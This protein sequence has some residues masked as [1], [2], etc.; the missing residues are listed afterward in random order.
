MIFFLFDCG[1]SVKR[2]EGFFCNFFLNSRNVVVLVKLV[3]SLWY[4][5][6]I[7]MHLNGN[8]WNSLQITYW[9][10]DFSFCRNPFLVVFSVYYIGT[11]HYMQSMKNRYSLVW[12]LNL[13]VFFAKFKLSLKTVVI[14]RW[15]LRT[16]ALTRILC[17]RLKNDHNLCII[18]VLSM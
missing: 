10:S 18:V 3:S 6:I 5:N 8:P 14:V 15:L 9:I 1:C 13:T 2:I 16:A 4:F 17:P 12:K 7:V 11:L